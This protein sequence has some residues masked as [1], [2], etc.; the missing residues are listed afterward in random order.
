MPSR[1]WTS[2]VGVEV[3][4]VASGPLRAVVEAGGTVGRS[5]FVQCTTVTLPSESFSTPVQRTIYA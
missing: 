4:V 2:P 5:T 1:S 3:S